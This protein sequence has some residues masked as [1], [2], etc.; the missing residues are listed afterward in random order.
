M[1]QGFSGGSGD[2]ESTCNVGDL[3]SIPG[4]EKSPGGGHGNHSSILAWR[5]PMGRGVWW[6]NS[7]SQN[8]NTSH[9]N[10]AN[11]IFYS[12]FLEN[13]NY[14]LFIFYLQYC[15]SQEIVNA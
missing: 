11:N 13:K 7:A 15:S 1:L 2:K 9:K 10:P 14:I 8:M 6:A 4:S 12:K 3:G 5:I